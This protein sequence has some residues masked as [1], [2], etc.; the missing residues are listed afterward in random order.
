M[1]HLGGPPRSQRSVGGGSVKSFAAAQDGNE[2]DEAGE[3]K[4]Q[5]RTPH[6]RGQSFERGRQPVPRPRQKLGYLCHATPPCLPFSLYHLAEKTQV[7][8]ADTLKALSGSD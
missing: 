2:Q 3:Q 4:P 6:D 1:C 5:R 7:E 8:Q